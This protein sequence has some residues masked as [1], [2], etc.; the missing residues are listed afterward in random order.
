MLPDNDIKILIVLS[1]DNSNSP[2]GPKTT[3]DKDVW[4]ELGEHGMDN[5]FSPSRNGREIVTHVRP[6]SKELGIN[7]I[8]WFVKHGPLVEGEKGL[9]VACPIRVDGMLRLG[10][11]CQSW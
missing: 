7:D 8:V 1:S 9:E 4:M 2:S 10:P 3:I 6:P 5:L 11:G